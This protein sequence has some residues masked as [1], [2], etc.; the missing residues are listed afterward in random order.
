MIE[1]A[2]ENDRQRNELAAF[3]EKYKN[4]FF[5]IAC[6]KLH[7]SEEAED[8]VQEAFLRVAN[9]PNKFLEMSDQERVRFVDGMLDMFQ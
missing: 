6:S 4:R 3:Y 2:L 8:A 7:N 5:S 9:D 1:A